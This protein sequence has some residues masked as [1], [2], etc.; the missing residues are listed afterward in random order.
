MIKH[1]V[2]MRY[3][4]EVSEAEKQ[5]FYQELEALKPR[6]PGLLA[7][8][9]HKNCSPE[10]GMDKGYQEG[11]QI[12]FADAAARD[13]YLADPDHQATGAKLIAASIGGVDGI[14]VFDYQLPA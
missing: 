12:D 3:K 11:F 6:M 10:E 13:A 7:I 5:G 9:Y 8:Q 4:P 14:F 2:L 1:L